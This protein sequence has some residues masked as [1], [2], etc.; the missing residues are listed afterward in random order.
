MNNSPIT[1][2]VAQPDAVAEANLAA[3]QSDPT[4][5]YAAQTASW[6]ENVN[7]MLQGSPQYYN[8]ATSDTF[9][10]PVNAGVLSGASGVKP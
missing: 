7:Q 3:K 2:K 5:Y 4:G 9:T 1:V 6:G 10:G 8:N